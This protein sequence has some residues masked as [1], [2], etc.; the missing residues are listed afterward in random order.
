MPP[1][2][3]TDIGDWAENF[4]KKGQK[5]MKLVDKL[6]IERDDLN[7]EEKFAL[8]KAKNIISSRMLETIKKMEMDLIES[9]DKI[10]SL[11]ATQSANCQIGSNVFPCLLL[12]P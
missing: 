5:W 11:Y 10:K 12:D 4:M 7:S 2:K 9:S 1:K 6:L 3:F 8:S